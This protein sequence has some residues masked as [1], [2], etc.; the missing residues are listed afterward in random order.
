MKIDATDFKM[1][2]YDDAIDEKTFQRFAKLIYELSG[3]VINEQKRSLLQARLIKRMRKLGLS[4]FKEYLQRVNQDTTGTELV[5][6]L[7]VISTNVTHFFRESEHFRVLAEVLQDLERA[8]Q[9]R[10]RIWCAASSTGEEPYSIA[11]T[12][13]EALREV[14]EVKILATDISTKV[15]ASA[16]LGV[17]PEN[18]VSNVQKVL[19][20]R[21][22]TRSKTADALSWQ[23]NSSLRRLIQFSR[24]NLAET[25]Y[26]L[27]G[28]LDVIFCRNVMIYF[29]NT[30]RQKVIREF[31][32]LL[33][34]GGYLIVGHAESLA[35]T[36]A[37][38]DLKA[39]G[40][41]IYRR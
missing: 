10:I 8:G 27:K 11:M 39:V 20:D 12:A 7:D 30:M 21:Y 3:I 22:F 26:P 36:L 40:S 9:K 13:C 4:S 37:R 2:K 35:G 17:Y 5:E 33:R 15:L 23:A 31:V 29:D 32:R 41:A 28:P 34:P 25:P 24:L 18:R 16:R 14:S 1:V 38:A 6:L 19:L